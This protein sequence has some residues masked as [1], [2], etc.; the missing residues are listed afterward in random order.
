MHLLVHYPPNTQPT[1]PVN[2]LKD[3]SSCRLRQECNSHVRRYLW[4]GHLLATLV[5]E[6]KWRRSHASPFRPFA[7]STAVSFLPRH[8]RGV[9]RSRSTMTVPVAERKISCVMVRGMS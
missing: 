5:G 1:K 7:V 4:G 6:S 8:R 9:A 2:S 3:V